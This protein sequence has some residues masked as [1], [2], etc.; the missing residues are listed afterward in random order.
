M[1]PASNCYLTGFIK[2]SPA[3][4]GFAWRSQA[5]GSIGFKDRGILVSATRRSDLTGFEK[6]LRLGKKTGLKF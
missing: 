5:H 4:L 3:F 2:Y 1:K 6:R